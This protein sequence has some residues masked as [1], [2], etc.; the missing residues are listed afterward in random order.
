MSIRVRRQPVVEDP[1]LFSLPAAT[2][3]HEPSASSRRSV[4]RR[5]FVKQSAALA[6]AGVALSAAHLSAE[7]AAVSTKMDFATSDSLVHPPEWESLNPG[8]WKVENGKLRRRL[9]NVGDRARRTGFPF[10]YE[11]KG[12]VMET[13]YDPSQP[14]GILYRRDQF[15]TGKY[16]I[17]AQ[18]TYHADAMS[19]GEGD[20]P[21][22]NMYQPGYGLM[23]IALGSKS[24]LE[25]Y[26][27][28]VNA[29]QIAWA[30]DGK[31]MFVD[32]ARWKQ[33]V[34]PQHSK[35][36]HDAFD[37]SPGDVVDLHV[38]VV[39]NGKNAIVNVVLTRGDESVV[40]AKTIP[41]S[42]T[43]GYVGV[44]GRGLIDFSVNSIQI[45]AETAR[46]LNVKTSPCLVCY[47]LGD[48]L[49]KNDEGDWSVRFIGIFDRDGSEAE[50]RISDV[51]QPARA[52]GQ[53]SRSPEEPRSLTTIFG[54]T[55][56]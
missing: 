42:Q 27:K 41:T 7:V 23:G 19:P 43:E 30:D 44:V 11:S 14:S 54:A 40:W 12:N 13:D 50:I 55:R 2:M 4:D 3:N 28:V 25:S 17:Q 6:S 36:S 18:F 15:L 51:E 39:P 46:P 38:E 48:T 52:V 53:P 34:G 31:V 37:L 33:G 8:F 16:S 9:T 1:H 45:T 21:A 20:D 35:V 26:G 10:H 5:Q 29:S 24:L 47:P 22:W 56:R 49:L 32:R